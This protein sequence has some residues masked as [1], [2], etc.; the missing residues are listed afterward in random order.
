MTS[1]L[2]NDD[3]NY[4]GGLS[5]GRTSYGERIAQGD[6]SEGAGSPYGRVG[7]NGAQQTEAAAPSM[8]PLLVNRLLGALPDEDFER[9]LPGLE[10][11]S[12]VAVKSLDH[13]LDETRY[14]YFPE[15]AVISHVTAFSDGN[16]VEVALT[17][18]EGAADFGSVFGRRPAS[19]WMRVTVPGSALRMRREF[20]AGE[21]CAGGAFRQLVLEHAGRHVAQISQRSACANRHRLAERLAVWLLMVH[22]RAGSDQLLLTQE[23]IASR[24]G[25]RR[26]GITQLAIDLQKGGLIKYSRGRLRILDRHGLERAACECYGAVRDS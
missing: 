5:R 18:R 19:H 20:F 16:A 9:L 7:A 26:A 25:A 4:G 11:V 1:I 14:V 17:G 22:D 3:R 24:L 15:D 8:K 2:R 10:P 13:S 23:L 6:A 12:L 21:F